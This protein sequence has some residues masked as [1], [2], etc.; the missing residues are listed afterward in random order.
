MHMDAANAAVLVFVDG[1]HGLAIARSVAAW[2]GLPAATALR[3]YV[4][5]GEDGGVAEAAA[6]VLPPTT[7][8]GGAVSA[9]SVSGER[10]ARRLTAEASMGRGNSVFG[11]PGSVAAVV[12]LADAEGADEVVAALD[13]HVDDVDQ[14]VVFAS[15]GDDGGLFEVEPLVTA[16]A[17]ALVAATE[18]AAA[19][20]KAAALAAETEAAA[21]TG[22]EFI[23]GDDERSSPAWAAAAAAASATA[24]AAFW[25]SAPSSPADGVGVVPPYLD[26]DVGWQSDFEEA[27]WRQWSRV[28]EEM[29]AEYARRYAQR[30]AAGA[31]ASDAGNRGA[32]APAWE[33]W[34]AA[35][36]A[37]WE[38][39][40]WDAD[41]W[42][43]YN[44]S[45][46][47]DPTPDAGGSDA[48]D[49]RRW[50]AY[51]SRRKG[52][53]GRTYNSYG[54]SGWGATGGGGSYTG[55]WSGGRSTSSSYGSSSYS[56]SSSSSS[57]WASSGGSSM[58]DYFVLLG[59]TATATAKE[60]KVAY[61]TAAK[62]WHP[63]RNRG[64]EAAA[65]A[66]MKK[67]VVAYSAI[68]ERNGGRR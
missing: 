14:V 68:C 12:A 25:T 64:D 61:R 31:A 52:S 48:A 5:C 7:A 33:A 24:A 2:D 35:N 32:A 63:D 34:F 47:T 58:N 17:D 57:S 8:A 49:A 11:A 65:T 19:V 30:P 40:A 9:V 27:V 42:S 39:A 4:A 37:A 55:G 3:V 10:M 41:V 46:T 67:I 21:E 1:A 13:A 38:A 15:M 60:V 66:M 20:A 26:D 44:E 62:R 6:G 51:G 23:G 56:S 59:V 22:E 43:A 53:G 54:Q 36:A 16:A 45:W 18:V 29:A 50:A 28:R